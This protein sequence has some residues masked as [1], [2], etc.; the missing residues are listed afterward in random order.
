ME[1]N[2]D[3]IKKFLSALES[4][5]EQTQ[6]DYAAKLRQMQS[7][8][9]FGGKIEPIL[10]FLGTI[11]NPNTRSNKAN[12]IIRMRR[13]LGLDVEALEILREDLK[14]EIRQH[15]KMQSKKNNDD[16]ITYDELLEKLNQLSGR[17][18]I[19]NYMYV[20][21]GLRNQDINVQYINR[22][23]KKTPTENT[24]TQDPK[25]KKP[26]TEFHIVDYKT[27]GTYGPK[28]ITIRDKQLFDNINSL[29][30]KNKDYVFALRDGTKPT[31]NYMNVLAK[32]NSI[33]NY[34]EGRIAK[35]LVK[36]LIDT[37]QFDKVEELSKQRGTAMSTL[38]TT[39]NIM[40]NH[41]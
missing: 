22:H 4:V 39:Y 5:S 28:K 16:L 36:H 37:K 12:A 40:D 26:K 20:H 7:K 31:L 25:A 27:A 9:D 10:D 13:F 41:F 34:G 3:R 11:E 2:E 32:K 17:D 38:Y 8:I 1:K 29:D 33:N 23:Q 19:M 6:R 24:V 18:Y 21:H 30:L 14:S 35:I 15:R